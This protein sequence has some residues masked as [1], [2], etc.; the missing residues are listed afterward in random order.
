[1]GMIFPLGSFIGRPT[2]P[3]QS[4]FAGFDASGFSYLQVQSDGAPWRPERP[5]YIK[6]VVVV[7]AATLPA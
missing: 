4:R 7:F 2:S 6:A 3:A 5:A 1:M